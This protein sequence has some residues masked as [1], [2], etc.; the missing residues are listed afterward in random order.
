MVF[1]LS[2]YTETKPLNI[3]FFP[4]KNPFSCDNCVMS[5][6]MY[7]KKQWILLS[8]PA[9]TQH[10]YLSSPGSS[11]WCY[12]FC[13]RGWWGWCF[14]SL[15]PRIQ[16]T[17]FLNFWGRKR[18]SLRY[19]ATAFTHFPPEKSCN[20]SGFIFKTVAQM[21][22]HWSGTLEDELLMTHCY[23]FLFELWEY[24]K[25][26]FKTLFI[27]T[28]NNRYLITRQRQLLHKA[29]QNHIFS[30]FTVSWNIEHF[31]SVQDN[32]LPVVH[33]L[34]LCDRKSKAL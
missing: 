15:A 9:E 5:S 32:G 21:R 3:F 1:F 19:R 17:F 7:W 26:I 6:N 16:T 12:C 11:S 33:S 29:F 22:I 18:S 23:E 2:L 24:K 34:G 30:V 8:L 13:C 20:Y 27:K 10:L 31:T 25:S 14:L 4:L 28:T